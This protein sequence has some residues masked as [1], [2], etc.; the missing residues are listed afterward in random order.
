VE[1]LYREARECASIGAYTAAAMAARKILMNVAV[2]QGA[3][4]N[5]TF[6]QYV[7]YLSDNNYIPPNGK[8]WVDHIRN[9]GN[10]ANHEI[11]AVS[12]T[13]V[14]DLLLFLQ[15]LL[16]FIYSFPAKFAT[17]TQNP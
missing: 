13:E 10:D 14:N 1:S 11:P 4:P 12:Q 9:T 6:V 8:V 15:F 2:A 3:K 16:T 7:N 17:P 5:L